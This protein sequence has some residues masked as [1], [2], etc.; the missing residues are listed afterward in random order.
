MPLLDLVVFLAE[1]NSLPDVSSTAW[2]GLQDSL[3]A[4]DPFSVIE[5]CHITLGWIE[6]DG[7]PIRLP[8]TV[9]QF[10]NLR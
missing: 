6:E 10:D 4:T 2:T 8:A 5:L 9:F 7:E 3:Q 1:S